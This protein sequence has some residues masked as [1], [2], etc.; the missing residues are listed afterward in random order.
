MK[1]CLI[2]DLQDKEVVDI[3][4]GTRYGFISDVEIDLELGT[5][6]AIVVA[7]QR[8]AFGLLGREPDVAFPWSALKRI[9]SDIILA[10]GGKRAPANGR[11]M[12]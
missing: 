9:G 3:T 11:G 5:V 8:R 2:S 1:I 12:L 6:T 4:D 10:D 7:G